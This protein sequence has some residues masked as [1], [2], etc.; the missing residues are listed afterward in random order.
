MCLILHQNK[1]KKNIQL[2]QNSNFAKRLNKAKKGE[3]TCWKAYERRSTSKKLVSMVMDAQIK[4]PGVIHSGRKNGLSNEEKEKGQVYRA[5]HVFTKRKEAENRIVY[6]YD[7]VVPVICR[8]K[9]LV[10]QGNSEDAAFS[11]IRIEKRTWNK[12]FAK[13]NL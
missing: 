1:S 11:K 10:A 3:I 7:V 13:K 6:S 2:D 4:E 12:I 9:D 5:I 8:K